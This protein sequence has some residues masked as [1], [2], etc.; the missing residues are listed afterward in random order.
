MYDK[1]MLLVGVF[2]QPH[3]ERFPGFSQ[4]FSSFL[5]EKNICNS[6]DAVLL[7]LVYA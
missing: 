4:Y 3:L 5:V 7:P 6:P 1:N 2:L